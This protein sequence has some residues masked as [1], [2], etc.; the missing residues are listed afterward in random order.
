VRCK[1]IREKTVFRPKNPLPSRRQFLKTA[2]LVA[3]AAAAPVLRPK[4]T[5]AAGYPERPIK[6][7]VP[8]APAGPTDIMARN[9]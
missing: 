1:K 6:I 9:P 2:S 8:F 5:W 4:R 3:S 7:I